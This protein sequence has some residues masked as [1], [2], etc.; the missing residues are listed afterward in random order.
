MQRCAQCRQFIVAG[1]VRQGDKLYCNA[2]CMESSQKP[3]Q[4]CQECLAST[5]DQSTGN[6]GRINGIGVALMRAGGPPCPQCQSLLSR[7]WVT[8]L[9]IPL[10]PLSKYRVLY[11]VKGSVIAGRSQFIS[12]KMRN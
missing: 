7:T 2:T 3:R 10:I 1:G 4:F 8:I 6:L 11:L 5:T 9:Y 12:R